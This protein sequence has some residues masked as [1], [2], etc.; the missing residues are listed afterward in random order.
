MVFSEI[1]RIGVS[2]C[3]ETV[4]RM[5]IIFREQTVKDYGIDAIIEPKTESYAS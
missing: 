5:N 4:S 2:I 1:D 3:Q